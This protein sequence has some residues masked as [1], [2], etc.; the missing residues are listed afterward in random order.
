[1]L[2][3][4]QLPPRWYVVDGIG[5]ATLCKDEADANDVAASSFVAW[6]QNGPYRAVQLVEATPSAAIEADRARRVPY[7]VLRAAELT[8]K[9]LGETGTNYPAI[10]TMLSYIEGIAAAPAKEQP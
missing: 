4:E 5:M 2:R 9:D 7:D 10:R 6:P 8:R 1:M 3:D